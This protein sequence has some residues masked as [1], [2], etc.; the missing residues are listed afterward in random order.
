MKSG[1]R[2]FLKRGPGLALAVLILLGPLPPSA[3]SKQPDTSSADP[4]ARLLNGNARF[5]R[6]VR[7]PA[8]YK[9]ERR[10]LTKVQHPYAIVLSCSDSRVPPEI[11]FDESLGKLFVVRV[12]GNVVDPVTLGS[13]EYAAEH[14]HSKLL[15]V[16]GHESCGAV[17]ATIDGGHSSPGIE[18][19]VDR[20]KP[21]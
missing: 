16:L 8:N 17:R 2:K 7:R 18:A 19:I 1:H 21:A 13:I 12:A 5:V 4:L 15:F 3:S 11:V 6:G 10:A 20:I 9:R 14:L